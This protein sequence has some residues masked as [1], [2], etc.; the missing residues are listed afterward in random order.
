MATDKKPNPFVRTG[1]MLSQKLWF[2]IAR[3]AMITRNKSKKIRSGTVYF[4][5]VVNLT[6]AIPRKT[7]DMIKL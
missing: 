3:E 4:P 1:R 5:G 2:R 6:K 7:N